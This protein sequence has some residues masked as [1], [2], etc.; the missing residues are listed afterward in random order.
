MQKINGI[1]GS[2]ALVVLVVAYLSAL[3]SYGAPTA[4]PMT[5]TFTSL[6]QSVTI[7]LTKDGSP[8]SAMDILGWQFLASGHDYKHMLIV[9]KLDGALRI[10]PSDTLEVGSYDLNIET[11]EG[12][13]IVLVLAPLSDLPDVV[14]KMAAITGQSEKKN[15]GK[16]GLDDF[17]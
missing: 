13:V 16:T 7:N 2:G 3:M 6:K 17:G 1:Y 4:T 10:A 14:E 8:I 11:T 9:E 5:A 12:A 15:C